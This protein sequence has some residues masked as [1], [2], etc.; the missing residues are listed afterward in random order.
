MKQVIQS[1][2]LFSMI[3]LC[4]CGDKNEFIIHACSNSNPN[5]VDPDASLVRIKVDK[6]D[7]KILFTYYKNALPTDSDILGKEYCEIFDDKNWVCKSI[8]SSLTVSRWEYALRDGNLTYSTER[9]ALQL[10][11]L[12][13]APIYRVEKSGFFN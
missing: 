7:K 1:M 12:G 3:A 6:S 5:C 9:N 11:L 13:P 4:G 2:L 10:Q 8:E